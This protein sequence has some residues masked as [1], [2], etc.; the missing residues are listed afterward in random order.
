MSIS[1]PLNNSNTKTQYVDCLKSVVY[2]NLHALK[3]YWPLVLLSQLPLAYNL[4]IKNTPEHPIKSSKIEAKNLDILKQKY[5]TPQEIDIKLKYLN[6]R[7]LVLQTQ[8]TKMVK[9]IIAMQEKQQTYTDQEKN[10]E[11]IAHKNEKSLFETV[12]KIGEHIKNGESY[13]NFITQIPSNLK[14]NPAYEILNKYSTK[15]PP[16]FNELIK[17]FE[18]LNKNHTP[19]QEMQTVPRWLEKLSTLFKG[20][21]KITKDTSSKHSPFEAIKE[22][23]ALRDF[24]LALDASQYTDST[25]IKKWA[26]LVENRLQLEQHY[27]L[28]AEQVSNI[29]L[30]K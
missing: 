28:F 22:A 19:T 21:I 7:F 6:E 4:S 29:T 10:S 17:A 1:Q 30:E 9:N 5:L 15:V 12:E 8:H 2:K 24:Q 25:V 16:T 14:N 27:Q 18:E 23:L 11:L 20:E 3:T 26:R 13:G